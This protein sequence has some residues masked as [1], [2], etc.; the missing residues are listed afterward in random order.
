MEIEQG[1]IA[2]LEAEP[3]REAFYR[4]YIEPSRPVVIRGLAD[5]WANGGDWS[6]DYLTGVLGERTVRA[7][8]S[9]GV[10]DFDR[11][12]DNWLARSHDRRLSFRE[13]TQAI[14]A[15][16]EERVYL[17]Q[18]PIPEK[19]PELLP[20]LQV[21]SLIEEQDVQSLNLWFGSAGNISSLHYDQPNNFL[22]QMHGTK[23][24]IIFPPKELANLYPS[25]KIAHFSRVDLGQPDFERFPQ[26]AQAHG[27]EVELQAGDTLFLPAFW[28]HQV[29]SETVSVS[30]NLFWRS[31]THQL[32]VPAMN[33]ALAKLYPHLP[34]KY[35]QYK[36]GK[37]P[38]L[39]DFAH[40]AADAGE[41]A[42]GAVFA[43][44]ALQEAM[45]SLAGGKQDPRQPLPGVEHTEVLMA[46][47]VDRAVIDEQ[48]ARTL[49]AWLGVGLQALQALPT[50]AAVPAAD[51][52][53]GK[54]S[55]LLGDL[56]EASAAVA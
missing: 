21:P 47:L 11:D 39:I 23:R 44:A 1:T 18:R 42:V 13:A 49:T 24:L 41:A 37:L 43:C 34:L 33:G 36:A 35:R 4:D 3:T 16:G 55:A 29:Y 9:S 26:L 6:P 31:Y 25:S 40:F 10:Y 51:G 53:V 46:R 20:Y 17:H 45:V 56:Q 8:F 54:I 28:W 22:V 12:S 52:L 2:R 32:L 27:Y 15:G 5:G 7:T 30:V 19:F 48:R 14:V 50:G 38:R